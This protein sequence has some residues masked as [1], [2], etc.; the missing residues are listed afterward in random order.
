MRAK[1]VRD[2]AQGSKTLRKYEEW[3]FV[4]VLDGAQSCLMLV[5]YRQGERRPG[6]KNPV[7]ETAYG[8]GSAA[9]LPSKLDEAKR[10]PVSKVP[11]PVDVL[12]DAKK[13]LGRKIASLSVVAIS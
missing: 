5:S 10:I 8:N 12:D 1:V 9:H 4:L 3:E 11:L 7:W 2:P 6:R 13:D